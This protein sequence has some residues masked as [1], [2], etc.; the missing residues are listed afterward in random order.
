M[1]NTGWNAVQCN[2]LEVKSCFCILLLKNPTVPFPIKVMS[3]AEILLV[4]LILTTL[5][6][7]LKATFSTM[8]FVQALCL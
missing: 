2:I 3:N 7:T 6:Y 1:A 8:L 5:H 4:L